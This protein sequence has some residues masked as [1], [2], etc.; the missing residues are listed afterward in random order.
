V[1]DFTNPIDFWL[2]NIGSRA[3]WDSLGAIRFWLTNML[4][5]RRW[6]AR[7]PEHYVQVAV[8]DYLA[9]PS[10]VREKLA[11]RL[12]LGGPVTPDVPDGFV[13]L[14]PAT[15]EQT[16]R[17]ASDVRAIYSGWAEF[18]LALTFDDWADDFLAQ[19]ATDELLDRFELFWNSTSHTNL[20][21]PGPIADQLAAAAVAHSGRSSTP[22][23]SRWFYHECFHLNSDDWRTPSGTLEHYLGS[24]EDEIVLPELAAHACIALLYLDRVAE[25]ITKRAY[26]ALPIR[27][28]S[29][30]QRV[31]AQRDNFAKWDMVGR[32][33]EVERHIDEANAA[34]EKFSL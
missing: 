32:L 28:T 14:S 23:L 6:A 27:E 19:P 16:E 34:M 18:D 29:M 9:D 1:I 3:V 30:Y 13:R 26:S 20:D 33:E 11:A 31:I 24:L 17:A 21:W 8:R 2:A 4:V 12:G 15:Y 7:H 25:N 5:V 22:N 10:G